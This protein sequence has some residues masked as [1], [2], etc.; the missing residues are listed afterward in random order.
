M[1]QTWTW[2]AS[3]HALVQL[4]DVLHAEAGVVDLEGAGQVGLSDVP[5]LTVAKVQVLEGPLQRR[6]VRGAVA[7]GERAEVVDAVLDVVLLERL[8]P[9]HRGRLRHRGVVERRGR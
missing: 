5:L 8:R 7:D 9:R 4:P 3:L 1:R 6:Q 2:I